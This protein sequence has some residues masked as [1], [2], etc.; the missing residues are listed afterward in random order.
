MSANSCILKCTLIC[1]AGNAFQQKES[2]SELVECQEQSE[3]GLPVHG[4][5]APQHCTAAAEHNRG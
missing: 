1:F 3:R 2:I 4:R 5:Q